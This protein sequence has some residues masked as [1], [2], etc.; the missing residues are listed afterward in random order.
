MREGNESDYQME[1]S[2]ME[3]S[4]KETKEGGREGDKCWHVSR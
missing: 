2:R 1:V 4:E 3:T